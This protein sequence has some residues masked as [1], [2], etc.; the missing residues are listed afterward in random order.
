MGARPCFAKLAHV[1]SRRPLYRIRVDGRV[2]LVFRHASTLSA[3]RACHADSS[4]ASNAHTYAHAASDVYPIAY[5]FPDH[6]AHS[7]R[8][9]VALLYTTHRGPMK[10]L[11]FRV[12]RSA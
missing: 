11:F 3:G 4:I 12:E 5:T 10:K 2:G 7:N 8:D 6:H 9:V 1:L